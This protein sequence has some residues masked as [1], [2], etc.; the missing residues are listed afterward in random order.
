MRPAGPRES[1]FYCKR[2]PRADNVP[3]CGAPTGAVPN[4]M[5]NTLTIDD[6]RFPIGRANLPESISPDQRTL[7]IQ[8]IATA[9]DQLRAAAEGLTTAQLD[10]PY[11][12]GGWTARQVIHHLPDSHMNAYVR[13]KLG[14]TESHPTVS[15][16]DERLW[17]ELADSR[18]TPI[19]VSL[20]LFDALHARWTDL[21]RS[22]SEEDYRRTYLHPE[23]GIV[24]VAQALGVY[25]WHGKHHI[26]HIT[27]LRERM[28]W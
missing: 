23:D 1:T 17:A 27:R 28:S 8:E 4:F 25:A 20:Q 18:D 5:T 7:W 26:A 24:Q 22:L 11:R 21:L 12:E 15:V 9:P 3:D 16:Y 2:S 6:P 14:L 10:T 19:E 13:M